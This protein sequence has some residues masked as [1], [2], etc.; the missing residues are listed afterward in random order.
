MLC[1]SQRLHDMPRA[2]AVPIVDRHTVPLIVFV[3]AGGEINGKE[4]EGGEKIKKGKISEKMP[5]RWLPQFEQTCVVNRL[6]G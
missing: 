2:A 1:P 3:E 6:K 4:D 5:G